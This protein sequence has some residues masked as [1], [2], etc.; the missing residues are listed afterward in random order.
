MKYFHLKWR[1]K[2][3]NPDELSD[4]HF[5]L[6]KPLDKEASNFLWHFINGTNLH[7]QIP[8]EHNFFRVIDKVNVLNENNSEI[9]KWLYQ[10]GLPF[11]KSVYLS[12]EPDVAMTVP[13]K[14]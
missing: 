12:W 3:K 4:R 5:N 13:W 9:K 14:I 1:F 8:F 11:K 7:E 10:R 2:D 6:L